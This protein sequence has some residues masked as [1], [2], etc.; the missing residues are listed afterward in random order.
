MLLLQLPAHV[1]RDILLDFV[2]FRSLTRLTE[3]NRLAHEMFT[4]KFDVKSL[5]ITLVKPVRRNG[6]MRFRAPGDTTPVSCKSLVVNVELPINF[7][8]VVGLA[9]QLADNMPQKWLAADKASICAFCVKHKMQ[10]TLDEF[11]HG[12]HQIPPIDYAFL[13][14]HRLPH[15]L[16]LPISQQSRLKLLH[17]AGW[18]NDISILAGFAKWPRAIA[19]RYACSWA[20]DVE[21]LGDL[22]LGVRGLEHICP[23]SD[24]SAVHIRTIGLSISTAGEDV[25]GD[26]TA[27]AVTSYMKTICPSVVT[28]ALNLEICFVA[29]KAE[30]QMRIS[31]R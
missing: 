9:Q 22:V 28:V 14:D 11:I 18:N 13:T 12:V 3:T 29:D 30:N 2:N 5:C 4:K 10:G 6:T 20:K 27:G 16:P 17:F 23:F 7:V 24:Q 8:Q 1:Y 26:W 19:I 31:L 21:A 15:L 25:R